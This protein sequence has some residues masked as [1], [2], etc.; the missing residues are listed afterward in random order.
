MKTSTEVPLMEAAK[1]LGLGYSRALRLVLT[2]ALKGEQR[3]GRWMV[4]SAS[5]RQA[6]LRAEK[7]STPPAA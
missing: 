6:K 4:D 3:F 1:E 2:G 7:E 5:L